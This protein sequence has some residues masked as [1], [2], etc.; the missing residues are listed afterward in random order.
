MKTMTR[1]LLLMTCSLVALAQPGVRAQRP[2]GAD[3]P[4]ITGSWERYR[5]GPRPAGTE[6]RDPTVPPAPA[7]APLKPQYQK[8]WQAKV[9]A[10]RAADARGE[11][12][13]A[14]V[15]HCL[16]EGMPAMM[17]GP[18]PLEILQSKGQVTI[19]EEAYTQVRR[20]LLNRPQK[21]IDDVEPGFFG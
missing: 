9:Q 17:G 2:V 19:I 5:G 4:D 3:A 18:F 6:G 1:A 11:P 15:V 21:A 10:A 12:L 8:E 14:G 16:P 13:A 7:P 20:I